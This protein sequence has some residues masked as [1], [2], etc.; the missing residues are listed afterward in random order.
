MRLVSKFLFVSAI[1]MPFLTSCGTNRQLTSSRK[2]RQIDSILIMQ[3]LASI[4]WLNK[5]NM[6]RFDKNV[7][8]KVS[9]DIFESIEKN[10]PKRIVKQY[11]AVDSVELFKLYD[12]IYALVNQVEYAGNIDNIPLSSGMMEVLTNNNF[13]YAIG[14]YC[15][16]FT[17]EK[18]G[19]GKEVAKSFA[20]ALLSLGTLVPEPVKNSTTVI[21][22]IVDRDKKNITFY[23]RKG[24]EGAEPTRK[25]DLDVLIS[26]MLNPYFQ[27][28]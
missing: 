15:T 22:F 24:V 25:N 13:K 1:A 16:G 28:Q 18:G 2:P 9:L 6:P 19:Y 26:R 20:I 17:R 14:A 27:S 12:E 23:R 7:S 10:L 5:N 4:E 21:C 3:P 8:D 11:L